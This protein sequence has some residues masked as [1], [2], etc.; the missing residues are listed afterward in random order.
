MH[1]GLSLT[2]AAESFLVD[3][4]LNIGGPWNVYQRCARV[5]FSRAGQHFADAVLETNK[6]LHKNTADG[7]LVACARCLHHNIWQTTL[8]RFDC[9]VAAVAGIKPEDKTVAVPAGSALLG[10]RVSHVIISV[11]TREIYLPQ[12]DYL[13]EADEGAA[14][15][16]QFAIVDR[17]RATVAQQIRVRLRVGLAAQERFYATQEIMRLT[18]VSERRRGLIADPWMGNRR[19][20]TDCSSIDDSKRFRNDKKITHIMVPANAALKPADR[21]TI[22]RSGKPL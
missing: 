12:K 3:D 2:G 5:Q 14:A 6:G 9:P 22:I 10:T 7:F 4:G 18:H 20:A 8:L 11:A 13:L 16:A 19:H 21:R 1:V 17:C 15:A